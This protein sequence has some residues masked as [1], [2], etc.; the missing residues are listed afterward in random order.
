MQNRKFLQGKEHPITNDSV[1]AAMK[2][3]SGVDEQIKGF[4]QMVMQGLL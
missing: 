4:L 1:C 2:A 3:S